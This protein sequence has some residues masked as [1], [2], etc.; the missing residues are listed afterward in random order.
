MTP[1]I[2]TLTESLNSL[3]GLRAWRVRVGHGSF[4][5]MDFGE[6]MP[7]EDPDG[8]DRGEWHLWV[9]CSAWR[10]ESEHDVRAGSEDEREIID[11]A[12]QVI[13]NQELK[14][15]AV[16]T[17]SLGVDLDFG[18]Y[19]FRVFPVYATGAEH[20]MLYT[21]SGAVL[22]AGPGTSWKWDE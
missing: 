18:N 10:I 4:V 6:R 9:Y 3:V 2:A 13:E 8:M 16:S 14:S 21:P 17:P 20:W 11:A 12:L 15:V 7:A 19:V 22:V 5:T 1:D